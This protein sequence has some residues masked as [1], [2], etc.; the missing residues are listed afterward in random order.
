MVEG[1][2]S[3]WETNISPRYHVTK[4]SQ[5]HIQ[6][7]FLSGRKGLGGWMVDAKACVLHT[8]FYITPRMRGMFL[9][10]KQNDC[11]LQRQETK[12]F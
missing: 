11:Y 4:T 7:D 10:N 12:R 6:H 5:F 2:E 1:F 3:K 9:R 8:L